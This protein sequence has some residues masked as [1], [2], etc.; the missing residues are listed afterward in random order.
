[1][2]D[3]HSVGNQLCD[4]RQQIGAI[5]IGELTVEDDSI[6][7]LFEQ[8][9]GLTDSLGFDHQDGLEVQP[10][11]N[12]LTD[13]VIVVD[14]EHPTRV[15]V[16]RVRRAR[17]THATTSTRE[18]L[19][20]TASSGKYRNIAHSDPVLPRRSVTV[21]V[22]RERA[23][24]E[25]PSQIAARLGELTDAAWVLSALCSV[26]AG[27]VDVPLRHD[28]PAGRVLV[29]FG[30]FQETAKGLVPTAACRQTLG[31]RGSAFADGI[32]ST[33]GQAATA[34][35]RGNSPSGWA[36]LDN[37]ILL[38][39]GRASA[40]GGRIT[41]AFALPVLAGLA[42]RFGAAGGGVFLDV[43]V[44]VAELACAFCEAV[45]Q[46]R[47]V[48]IDPM[49]QAIELAA[50]TVAA[51]GL[52]DRIELRRQG[53]EQLDDDSVFDLA[54]MPL[55]F[56]PPVVVREGLA[57]VWR[58]LNP[59]GWLLLPGSTMEPGSGGDVARWQVHLA[60]GTLLTDDERTSL[61]EDS[62]FTSLTRLD[63]PPGAPALLAARRPE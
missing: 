1:V 36:A 13:V 12:Q 61:L 4:L 43:G 29:S 38:A 24:L 40:M 3:H 41:A 16:L 7:T 57:R 19:T 54:W 34:A 49:P 44:G 58:A 53:V 10:D 25:N 30:F 22:E 52:G 27:G 55:P 63:A 45:P 35:M 8:S 20:S 15:A 50:R 48:G 32:R 51:H 60:G 6:G 46:S 11:P 28:D 47:V 14:H 33:L 2:N 31:D 62:G 18:R 5:T 9:A 42:E 23:P 56:M 17:R 21:M 59:G 37:E 39:Q 26:L